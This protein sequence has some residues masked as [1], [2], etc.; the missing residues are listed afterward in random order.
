[1]CSARLSTSGSIPVRRRWRD[2]R[3]IGRCARPA[4]GHRGSLHATV[5][6]RSLP[7]PASR[8]FGIR[9]VAQALDHDEFARG[10]RDRP[11]PRGETAEHA[12]AAIAVGELM[13]PTRL[14]M[15]GEPLLAGVRVAQRTM[16][17]HRDRACAAASRSAEAA[18]WRAGVAVRLTKADAAFESISSGHA[19]SKCVDR[20]AAMAVKS[21]S[22]RSSSGPLASRFALRPRVE[23]RDRRAPADVAACALSDRAA[24]R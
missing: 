12:D 10:Q 9:T 8:R 7:G 22:L 13:A 20:V 18:R 15:A 3:T 23:A 1:M 4:R 5:T 14:T 2:T 19:R 6:L 21:P 11:P 24:I 17:G 16:V